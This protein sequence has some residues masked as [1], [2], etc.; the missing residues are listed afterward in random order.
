MLRTELYALDGT[1][2][3]DRPYTVT[4]RAYGLREESPPEGGDMPRQRIFF[5]HPLAQRTTQWERG[6]EPMTQ[7]AFTDAYDTYGQPRRQVSLAVPRHR[8]YRVPAP[9]G[10][11]YLGTLAETQYAQRDDAERYMVNR[12]SASM[13]FE[14]LNDGSQTVYDLYQQIQAGTAPR[15]LFG[16]IFNYYDGDA[17]VGLPFGQLGDFGALVRT[18]SLALTEEIIRVALSDPANPNAPSMPPYLRPEGV[19][20]W[21]AEYPQEF[22]DNTPA[23]AGYTF[24]DG[25][26]HWMRGYFADGSRVAFDFQIPGFPRRGLPMTTRDPLGSDTTIAYDQPFDLLPV[27]V[28]DAVGLTTSAE[29]DYRVLQPRMVTDAN[30]NR[31]AVTFSPLGLVISTAVMGKAGE[32]V[33]DTLEVSGSRL[34]YDFFAFVNRR[35]PVFVR[36]IVREH[37][38][39]ETDVPLPKRDETIE[40]IRYSDGFGRLLQ[41]RTQAEDVLFGDPHFGGGVLSA[42]QSSATTDAVGRRRTAGDL[43]NVIVSGREC[44]HPPDGPPWDDQP[45]CTDLTKARAY[46]EQYHY[47]AMGNMQR[48]EH[49]NDPAGGFVRV[50]TVETDNNRLRRM[51]IGLAGYDYTFD[52]NGNMRS[53]TTSLTNFLSA[54]QIFPDA[55]YDFSGTG[56]MVWK[57]S[58]EML[59][60]NGDLGRLRNVGFSLR[61]GAPDMHFSRLMTRLRVNI[62]INESGGVASGVTVF[63]AIPETSV[64][65]TAPLTVAVRAR[66][67]AATEQVWDFGDGTPILRTVRS[68]T[69]PTIAPAEGTH[70]YARPGRYV[71]KL[72]CVQNDSLSE[73]RISVVVSRNQKLGDPLIV[74]PRV[75]F[76][77]TAKTITAT[78]G[79]AV[80]QAGRML[81]RVGGL[82]AEGNSATFTL[83]PGNYI[84]DF[85][86]VRKLNFRAY[87]TQRYVNGA[88]PL[89]LQ[90]LSATTNRTFDENG[91]ETN[92]TGTSPLPARNELA[93][94]LFDKGAISPEDDWIFELIPEEI[95]GVPA[96]TAIDAEE[97]D[98][99]EIEDV[100]LSMEYDITPGGP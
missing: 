69:P 96:G 94:R 26:D 88:A 40:T 31:H 99:S 44:D 57:V 38:V 52:D 2:R 79:G 93:K 4:E 11:L 32:P 15:K 90:G 83:K 6:D 50:F 68:G 82:S 70:T 64:T 39:T 20:N 3:Q 76:D 87:S 74:W 9:A 47:D 89:P 80:Q 98:L 41:T 61:P 18:T 56:R 91:K 63:T 81:W 45:R 53:E 22:Q 24:A 77:T 27:Q 42:A 62:R 85:A 59:A 100:V 43:L 35:Q 19:T 16:Q 34:E 55:F 92:G 66:L 8:D 71:L 84:L 51:E 48:L 46:T 65:Q 97:L 73:F 28:T 13:S 60:L 33:G 75:T 17:F 78:T 25:S 49:R 12:V 54:R 36:S 67:D 30:G 37:H 14:I 5:P 21:P 29:Y 23:L 86:A 1:D 58:R 10:A 7:F 72:R 95:L